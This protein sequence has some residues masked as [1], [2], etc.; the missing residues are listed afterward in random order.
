VAGLITPVAQR[1]VN[2]LLGMI[3]GALGVEVIL[4][5]VVGSIRSHGSNSLTA[6][7]AIARGRSRGFAP[8][9]QLHVP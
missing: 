3:V 1:V 4:E 7:R 5:G 6:P 8:R 2:R 9:D